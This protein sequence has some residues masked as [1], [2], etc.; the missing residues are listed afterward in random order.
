MRI[1][2]IQTGTVA[3]TQS[4]RR[5]NGPG[6]IRRLNTLLDRR[7]TEPLPIYAWVVEHPEG[8]LVVDTGE[9]A[10]A[11]QPGYLPRWH[12]YFH[13]AVREWVRPEQEIGPQ[14]R[15]LGIDPQRD[16]RWLVMTH[17]HTDHAGGLAHFSGVDILVSRT[18]YAGAQGFHGQLDG[19]LN[20]RWPG[21]FAPRL[22]D[23]AD[24]PY[25]P[26]AQSLPLTKAG[27]IV[28]V[29][30]PGHTRG[31]LSV[32]VQ[33]GAHAVFLA[34]DTSYAQELLLAQAPD[35]V[36][37]DA[38]RERATHRHILQLAQSAPM[39]Y[40]PTHDPDSAQR[41]AERRI[42]PAAAVAASLIVS[43]AAA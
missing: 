39:V 35:G 38:A 14:L 9:T 27:D 8:V 2:A 22:L 34:G 36:G 23:F 33:D 4:W 37:P 13:F 16:V 17:L 18:E 3:I 26:F 21:W 24:R 7:W 25:G 43:K 1:H 32:V 40:L 15:A 6:A 31:H 5:G 28:L 29:P 12:P 30:T 42:V 11:S 41:L 19:Y 20:T 10:R